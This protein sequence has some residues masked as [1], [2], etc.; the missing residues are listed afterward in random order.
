METWAGG[1]AYERYVG[2]WSRIVA[3]KFVHWLEPARSARWL[4]IGCGTGALSQTILKEAAPTT[5]RGEDP[6]EI[7]VAYALDHVADPRVSFAVGDALSIAAPDQPYDYVVSALVINFIPDPAAA[8]K[9]MK[10]VTSA[11]GCVAGYVWDYAESMEMMR[12]FWDAAIELDPMAA[13][14]DEGARFKMNAPEPLQ[15]LWTDTGLTDV[16]VAPIEISMVFNDFDD[17]WT[18]FLGGQGPAPGYNM[19]LDED[20]R[21]KLR[22]LLRERLPQGTDSSISLKARAWAVTGTV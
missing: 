14:L 9:Q 20:A 7:H 1:E 22:E 10:G 15:E 12:F 2:R 18:P 3:T 11:G 13:E 6:S 19:S 21:T 16:K 8:L 5:V 4:D 17:Y